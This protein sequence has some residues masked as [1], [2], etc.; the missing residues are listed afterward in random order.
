MLSN[1]VP[2]TPTYG[3]SS[4]PSKVLLRWVGERR[5][6]KTRITINFYDHF[7]VSRMAGWGDFEKLKTHLSHCVTPTNDFLASPQILWRWV[8]AVVDISGQAA[9]CQW[10]PMH[11]PVPP[12]F[13]PALPYQ[14]L[15][16]GFCDRTKSHNH[17]YIFRGFNSKSARLAISTWYGRNSESAR[18]WTN[19]S[20]GIKDINSAKNED[21]VEANHLPSTSI[22]GLLQGGD[23][24]WL[25]GRLFIFNIPRSFSGL[26]KSGAGGGGGGVGGGAC[27]GGGA[28]QPAHPPD[29][30]EDAA[31]QTGESF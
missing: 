19:R 11:K 4:I 21:W 2:K 31:V 12:I 26:G 25:K 27:R 23:E 28:R 18:I 22:K 9:A 5:L 14:D 10:P 13:K 30:G 17:T 6:K 16:C 15:Y 8:V 3:M 24:Q 7:M 20:K 29:W 1:N